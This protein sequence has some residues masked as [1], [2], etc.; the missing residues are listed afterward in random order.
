MDASG[1]S[2]AQIRHRIEQAG[3]S[4]IAVRSVLSRNS[5]HREM[6]FDVSQVRRSLH[7]ETPALIGELAA[8]PGVL[9]VAW[10]GL[11]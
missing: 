10:D 7:C 6:Q 5:E 9:K 4:I 11:R 2:E 3:L 1:P 8:D